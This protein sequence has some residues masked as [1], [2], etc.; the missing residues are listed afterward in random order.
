M[1]YIVCVMSDEDGNDHE[2]IFVFP[3]TVNHYFM[4]EAIQSIRFGT[5]QNWC[6]N[7]DA[8]A[9]SAGFIDHGQCFGH[10]E[11]LKLKSRGVQ[12]TALMR[13]VL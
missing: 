5:Q 2:E 3:K 7:W 6:R 10:S 11:T 4:M 8:R 12:D 13:G 1:K 9:V